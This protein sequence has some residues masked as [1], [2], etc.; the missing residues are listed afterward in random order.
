MADET[1]A[2]ELE[3]QL[4]EMKKNVERA[5]ALAKTAI[6]TAA[7]ITKAATTVSELET[8]SQKATRLATAKA[9]EMRKVLL[10]VTI[11][12]ALTAVCLFFAARAVFGDLLSND[13]TNA[14]I[15]VMVCFL[16][17]AFACLGFGLFLGGATGT[18]KGNTTGSKSKGGS[19]D[20]ESTAPGL[21]V[22]V[23]ATVLI[24]FAIDLA[25]PAP[26]PAPAEKATKDEVKP[27]AAKPP[28]AKDAGVDAPADGPS[29]AAP[30]PENQ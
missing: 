10:A 11:P 29:D 5:E 21:V 18:F 8:E 19:I 15:A 30:T 6:A 22:I 24:Y 14:R 7:A 3:T 17:M 27:P 13:S 12:A 16:G 25:K 9:V 4:E 26:P 1:K 20:I 23:C 28:V 2:T